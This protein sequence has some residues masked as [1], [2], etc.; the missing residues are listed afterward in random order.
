MIRIFNYTDYQ[1]FLKDLYAD[2]KSTQKSFSYATLSLSVNGLSRAYLH[3]VFSGHQA[4]SRQTALAIAAALRLKKRETEYFLEMIAFA[5]SRDES[6]KEQHFQRMLTFR[7]SDTTT[8]VREE[9]FEYFSRWYYVVVRE[10]LATMDFRG[11]YEELAEKVKPPITPRQAERAVEVLQHLNLVK[12]TPA[13]RYVCK[14][15]ELSTRGDFE[16]P[17]TLAV[18]QS[19]KDIIQMA[20]DS[21]EEFK[22]ELRDISTL[23]ASVSTDG[24]QRICEELR[25]C[26]ERISQIVSS[27]QKVDRV[28]QLNIHLFPVSKLPKKRKQRERG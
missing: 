12:K 9:Q 17:K 15:R 18:R 6:K 13:G 8:K 20:A 2:L 11:N 23:T 25:A 27:D 16:L 14:E 10:L 5:R 28:Y 19:Q 22:P 7:K 21:I 1:K 3:R 4:L 26:R 24:F